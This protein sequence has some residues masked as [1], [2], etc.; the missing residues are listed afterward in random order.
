[1]KYDTEKNGIHKIV[2][3]PQ[4]VYCLH[5]KGKPFSVSK[6]S[7]QEQRELGV[8]YPSIGGISRKCYF[9]EGN[10]KTGIKNLPKCIRDQVEIVKYIPE[11]YQKE[12]LPLFKNQ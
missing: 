2:K 4:E 9:S 7:Y 12:E 10:A 1:M 5:Y 6:L 11:N 3:Y 8:Q